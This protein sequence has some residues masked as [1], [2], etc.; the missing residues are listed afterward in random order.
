MPRELLEA[1]SKMPWQRADSRLVI[2]LRIEAGDPVVGQRAQPGSDGT[3]GKRARKELAEL[4]VALDHHVRGARRELRDA[5]AVHDLV[6]E[7]LLRVHQDRFSFQGRAVPFR[8]RKL[9]VPADEG[10]LAT[11]QLETVPA[12]VE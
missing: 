11:A 4:V 7:P 8:K 10:V 6:A 1:P 9:A 12:L 2:R 3:E 5:R